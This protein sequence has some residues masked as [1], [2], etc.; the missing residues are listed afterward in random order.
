MKEIEGDTNRRLMLMM[1]RTSIVKMSILP[2]T[3]CRFKHYEHNNN[4]FHTTRINNFKLVRNHKGPQMAKG[5]LKKKNKTEGFTIP[6]TKIHY[7]AVVIKTVCYQYKN[8][9]IDKGNRIE[10]PEITILW[11]INKG[12]KNVQREKDSLFNKW[13]WEKLDK[14]KM[15]KN[16][17]GPFSHTIHKNKINMY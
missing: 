3:I 12:G 2:K 4:I 16:E 8:V 14:C 9:H 17:T 5:I 13:G 6:D 7:K 15:Q 11:S 10:N 1:E